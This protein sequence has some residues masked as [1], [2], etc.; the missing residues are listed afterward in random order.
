MIFFLQPLLQKKI[1]RQE[2]SDSLHD[3][4]GIMWGV[5]VLLSDKVVVQSS[6]TPDGCR[7]CLQMSCDKNLLSKT[8]GRERGARP[9]FGDDVG[10]NEV[11]APVVAV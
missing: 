2:G 6:T 11:E 9:N 4:G 5:A 3:Y 7:Y 10:V 8:S 1:L